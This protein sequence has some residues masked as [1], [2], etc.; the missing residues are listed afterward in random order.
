MD[1]GKKTSHLVIFFWLFLNEGKKVNCRCW[2][3]IFQFSCKS[4]NL[5]RLSGVQS[6]DILQFPE[7]KM[8]ILFSK[9]LPN[10]QH[11]TVIN[12]CSGQNSQENRMKQN[13]LTATVQENRY[14]VFKENFQLP[15]ST[16]IHVNNIIIIETY[17]LECSLHNITI[18]HYQ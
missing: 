9:I 16:T 11:S 2:Q 13:K 18:P 15:T 7:I 17:S 12:T 4:M 1:V 14:Y 6:M 8:S 10:L 3:H 5:V